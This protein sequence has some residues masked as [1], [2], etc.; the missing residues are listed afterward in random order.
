MAEDP[1]ISAAEKSDLIEVERRWMVLARSW[2]SGRK[3]NV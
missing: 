2:R 1:G 3:E